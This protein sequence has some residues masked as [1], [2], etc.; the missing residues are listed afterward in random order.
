MN[1]KSIALAATTAAAVLVGGTVAAEAQLWDRSQL[2]S[3]WSDTNSAPTIRGTRVGDQIHI[4][5]GYGGNTF[6]GNCR[7]IGNSVYCR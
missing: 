6:S 4:Q 7:Q 1:F 3:G 5:G 2:G